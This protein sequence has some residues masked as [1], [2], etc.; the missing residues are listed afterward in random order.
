[1]TLSVTPDLPSDADLTVYLLPEGAE[2]PAGSPPEAVRDAAREPVLLY[3]EGRR[4]ALV[5]LP[6][7]ADAAEAL[8][9]A[10]GKAGGLA[11]RLRARHVALVPPEGASAEAAVEGFALGA[12]RFTAYR[13]EEEERGPGPEA[14]TLVGAETEGAE[15]A[16][17]RA[18]A[19]AFARDLVNTSPHEKTAPLLAERCRQEAEAVGLR[20]EVWERERIEAERMGGLLAVARGS[21][22]PPR[23][24]VLEHAPEGTEGDPP[25][26]LVGK[27]VVFDT[28][29]LSLKPTK[30]SMD[31]MKAD[32][33]GGAAV[34]A[35][36]VAAARLGLPLRVVALIPMTDNRP[37]G[38]AYVPGDV[39]TMRNGLTVE[40]LNTDAEGR[41]LLADALDYAKTFEPRVVVDVATLTGAA[42][43]A[44]GTRV[45]GLFTP[46]D[47]GTRA[48]TEALVAAGRHTG[49]WVHPMPLH[50]HYGESLKS[51]VADMKN[52]GGGDAGAVTA[53]KFLER[54]TRADGAASYPWVHL[55]IAGPAF[56]DS[57]QPYRPKGGTG[58][59]VRLLVE[60][61]EG[62]A[63]PSEASPSR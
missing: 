15:R 40:V 16:L 55:D 32:M 37:G 1:M 39:V 57:P 51:E 49:E 31:Q 26:V 10:A 27:A 47:E 19:A 53:A 60:W 24:V 56:T 50:P 22:A 9:T 21:V 52:I 35:T 42:V 29:G 30:G 44:L 2:P 41:M 20:C 38:E 18:E 5:A 11:R 59:G 13:T 34:L 33:A 54:F 14:L 7:G 28:G 48:R 4:T 46:E 43:I 58:F 25:V 3:A 63:Q 45:A 6:E 36:M 61:L 23:F 62:M 17:V 12:Y 8:R